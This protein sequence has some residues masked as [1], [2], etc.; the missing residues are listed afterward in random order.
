[1]REELGKGKV[2]KEAGVVTAADLARIKDSTKIMSREEMEMTKRIA[3]EQREQQQQQAKARKTR[4]VN[5]D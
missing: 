2:P 5:M 3:E 4:M 1:M